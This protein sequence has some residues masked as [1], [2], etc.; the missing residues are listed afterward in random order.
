MTDGLEASAERLPGSQFL[1]NL[2]ECRVAWG[3]R[4]S[5]CPQGTSPA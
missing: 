4:I 3:K 2:L 1:I 5:N